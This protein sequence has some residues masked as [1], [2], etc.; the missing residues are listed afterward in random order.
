MISKNLLLLHDD[1]FLTCYYS[2]RFEDAGFQVWAA[3]TLDTALERM[4]AEPF[5][6][7]VDNYPSVT[8]DQHDLHAKP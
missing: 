8:Q 1:P 6:P 5:P 2:E 4:E 3:S 7:Q